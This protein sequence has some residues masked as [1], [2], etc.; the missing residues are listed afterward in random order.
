MINNTNNNNIIITISSNTIDDNKEYLDNILIDID[1][2]D[3]MNEIN[4]TFKA[5]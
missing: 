4:E 3:V 2:W 5:A 1:F